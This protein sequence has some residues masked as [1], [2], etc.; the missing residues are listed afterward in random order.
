MKFLTLG[1]NM[2]DIACSIKKAG[3]S[4]YSVN[5]FNPMDLRECTEKYVSFLG[6][7]EITTDQLRYEK[8]RWKEFLIENAVR[9]IEELEI[10]YIVPRINNEL[11][12]ELERYCPIIGNSLD[13]LEIPRDKWKVNL[14]AQKKGLNV[15]QTVILNE[16]F[17]VGDLNFP[18]LLKP[19][20]GA[21]GFGIE[22]IKNREDLDRVS[23]RLNPLKDYILQEFLSGES[24]N[25]N[26]IGDGETATP[27]FLS[28]QLFDPARK[29]EYMGNVGPVLPKGAEEVI[30]D[31][32]LFLGDLKL[33]GVLGVDFILDHKEEF[34]LI[35]VNPRLQGSFEVIEDSLGINMFEYHF[36]S[37]LGNTPPIP[38]SKIFAGK[39]VVNASK[40]SISPSFNHYKFIRDVPYENVRI[41]RGEPVCTVTSTGSSIKDVESKLAS[42]SDFVQKALIQRQN[43]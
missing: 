2:R 35:D 42:R 6:K 38:E 31:Y 24:Y 22:K 26:F 29:F 36:S 4:S 25:V 20:R 28:K 39:T 9:L 27:V 30:Q 17:D 13:D 37:W 12:G 8:D 1:I 15:P 33:K 34:Y 11:I 43:V 10:D 18:L 19:S 5:Y 16:S 3:H 23:S 14:L 21:R 32:A 7:K 41:N 40:D